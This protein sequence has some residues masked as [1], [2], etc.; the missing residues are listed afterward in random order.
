M[1][2]HWF[3]GHMTKALRM[4][5]DNVKT[6]DLIGYVLDARAPLSSLNPAFDS[7]FQ[8]K[9]VLFIL[10]KC[11]MADDSQTQQFLQYFKDKNLP[12]VALS[13]LDGKQIATLKNALY[14]TAKPKLERNKRK[15]LNIPVRVMI[16]GVPNCGKS[17]L[18][19]SLAK[20]KSVATGNTPGVT[21]GKQWVQMSN[22][23][24]LLDTPGT[25]WSNY[26]D[27]TVAQ[28]LCFVGSIKREVFDVY[29]VALLLIDELKAKYP[30]AI[31]TRYKV[32]IEGSSDEILAK[33][34]RARG[35]V[36][37]G[38]ELDLER[39]ALTVLDEYQ[40]GKLGKITFDRLQ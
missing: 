24:T 23:L 1:K 10:N 5:Q 14:Q 26:E 33:I 34:C 22:E 6:C 30:K 27:Q 32:A 18:I 25:C 3:P 7:L 31:E 40:K 28:R 11:D 39:G 21:R 12:C 35:Y 2:I 17:T 9:P 16:V 37:R 13:A 29:E 15:G 4:M 19:N 20:R 38:D 8:H 36:L